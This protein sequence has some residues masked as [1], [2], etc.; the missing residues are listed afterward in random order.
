MMGEA[1]RNKL[2]PTGEFPRGKIYESDEGA[3]TFRIGRHSDGTV[4]IDFGKSITWLGLEPD[5][6]AEFCKKI[7]AAAG[8][9]Q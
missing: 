9:T 3:F 8:R 4:I 6:A 2:G 7:L 1:K 5:I